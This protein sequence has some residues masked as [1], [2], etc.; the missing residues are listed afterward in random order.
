VPG[1]TR[2]LRPTPKGLEVAALARHH[3]APVTSDNKTNPDELRSFLSAEAAR[4]ER[5]H[6]LVELAKQ[7]YLAAPF[8]HYVSILD[9]A[10]AYKVAV[11]NAEMAD[12]DYERAEREYAAVCGQQSAEGFDS[13]YDQ[14]LDRVNA[15]SAQ[16]RS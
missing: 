9:A 12:Q 5:A 14:W 3:Y 16:D 8:N 10:V 13:S 7:D 2:A 4:R 1:G 6:A 15:Q 11:R